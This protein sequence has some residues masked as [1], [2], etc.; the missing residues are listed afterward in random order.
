MKKIFMAIALVIVSTVYADTIWKDKNLYTAQNA[1]KV[2]D[3]FTIVVSDISQM[4][5]T[6]TLAN[7]D[8]FMVTS[9]PDGTITPFLLR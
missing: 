3:I 7:N 6:L 4:R 2:G 9:A 5:F 1:I 8:A